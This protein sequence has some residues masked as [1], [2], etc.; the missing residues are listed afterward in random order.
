MH[1]P[2]S[3]P[4]GGS[5]DNTVLLELHRSHHFCDAD[6]DD[7]WG[8]AVRRCADIVP[9]LASLRLDVSATKVATLLGLGRADRLERE[10]A[11]RGLPS[12]RTLRNWY[13][14]VTLHDLHCQ[15]VSVAS[16]ALS[17][18]QYPAPYYRLVKE[19]TGLSWADLSGR[20]K[21]WLRCR[22]LSVWCV[23]AVSHE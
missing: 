11:R 4:P 2:P 1:L 13:Y 7:A 15:G 16:W 21:R 12:F 6:V 18:G 23:N 3:P 9:H 10:L 19:T 20:S 22:A 5:A 14:V 8:A 17:T